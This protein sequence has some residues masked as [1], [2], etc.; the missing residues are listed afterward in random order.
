MIAPQETWKCEEVVMKQTYRMGEKKRF[1]TK[2]EFF[3]CENLSSI[4]HFISSDFL[5]FIL[6]RV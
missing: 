5:L 6:K 3:F 4:R 1:L 2:I